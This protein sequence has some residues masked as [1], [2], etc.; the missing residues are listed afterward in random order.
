M[1]PGLD[2]ISVTTVAWHD[3]HFNWHGFGPSTWLGP[4]KA[5]VGPVTIVAPAG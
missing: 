1:A 5:K 3:G 2:V 4:T